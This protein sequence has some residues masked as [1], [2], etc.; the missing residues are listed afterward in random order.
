[1]T[2]GVLATEVRNWSAE[3]G[4]GRAEGGEEVEVDD[5]LAQNHASLVD[6]IGLL[7]LML[8]LVF[9]E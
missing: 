1:M 4:S 8:V 2:R 5:E 7:V 3:E 6:W 9:K